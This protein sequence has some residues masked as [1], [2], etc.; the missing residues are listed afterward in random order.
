[1]AGRRYEQRLRA[2]NAEHTRRR[3]LDAVAQRLREAPTEPVSLDQVARLARVVRST[4][5]LVFGSRAGLFDAFTDDLWARTGLPALTEAVA[6]PDARE[7]LRG[8]I[9]AGTRMYAADRDIYRVLHSMA[10]LDPDSVGGAVDKMNKERSGGM[11]H[12]A[13]R[14]AE[15]GVLRSDVTV[16]EAA[17]VLWVLCSFESFDL[18][19]T[20]RGMSVDDTIQTIISTAE[21][22]LL[23]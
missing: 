15:D 10:Q 9:A 22:A 23:V 1:M 16:E 13:R 6:H 8:G 7:H 12:L 19:Y 20:A 2:E 11:A 18:L 14:L 21:R 5:Y 3:I 4:I 17:N